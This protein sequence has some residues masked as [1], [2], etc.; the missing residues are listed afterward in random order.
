MSN[1]VKTV[2]F[3]VGLALFIYLISQF[4]VDELIS[5]IKRT[6]W[7]LIPIIG[8]WLVVYLLN[9]WAWQWIMKA[10]GNKIPFRD[11]FS[12]SISGFAMNYVTPFIN[13]GGEPYKIMVLKDK[14]GVSN[15]VASVI[16]Y[17]MLHFLSSFV[18]WI[19][20]ILLVLLS[21]NL[22]FQLQL[23]FIGGLAASLL[24]ILF[25]YSR[26]KKGLFGSIVKIAVKL[27][28]TDK[29]INKIKMKEGVLLDI[30][31]HIVSLYKNNRSSFYAALSIEFAARI[32]TSIEFI[33]I[34]YSI[35]IQITFREAIYI[36]AFSSFLINI[37][38]FIPMTLGVREGSLFFIMGILKLSPGIGIYIGLINRLRELFWIAVGLILIQ[39][40]K[41]KTLSDTSLQV[42]K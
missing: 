9:T 8:V 1:K 13:L 28:I 30:D 19:T 4:G 33:F 15:S 36:N 20:A 2:F 31:E 39:L 41:Y 5:G 40:R 29:W 25:F 23:I 21:L 35:G 7:W 14:I 32:V 11:L 17:S 10:E 38:F 26:H 18:F 16:L 12:L 24:G 27:P 22:S 42:K 6:G 37:F 3:I 34:L